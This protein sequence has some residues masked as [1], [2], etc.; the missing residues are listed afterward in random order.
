MSRPL[1]GILSC[2]RLDVRQKAG[3]AIHLCGPPREASVLR[4]WTSACRR[5]C[6]L[7][8]SDGGNF[9]YGDA[10]SYG[11]TGAIRLNKPIVGVTP[12]P[13]GN[14][15][16]FVASDGGVFDYGDAPYDESNV[17]SATSPT[18]A[19]AGTSPTTLQAQSDVPALRVRHA[20]GIVRSGVA[21][22]A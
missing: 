3:A 15:Y 7:V 13:T 18:F 12:S 9:S 22:S 8:A 4:D 2:P 1:K 19:I 6:W 11:S 21:W 20:A 17:G 14:G 16:W 5:R 10:P